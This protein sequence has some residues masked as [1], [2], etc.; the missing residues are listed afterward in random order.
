MKLNGSNG[1]L[2]MAPPGEEALRPLLE[3][4]GPPAAP[5]G[6]GLPCVRE[7]W[8][9]ALLPQ[10]PMQLLVHGVSVTGETLNVTLKTMIR[11]AVEVSFPPATPI[12]RKRGNEIAK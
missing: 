7:T 8:V 3:N 4:A 10:L 5:R 6:A 1:A 12:E 9:E 11:D 2:T